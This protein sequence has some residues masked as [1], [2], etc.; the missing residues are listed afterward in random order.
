MKITFV[1]VFEQSQQ[2]TVS[3]SHI[4]EANDPHNRPSSSFTSF[5]L[6]FSM[7]ATNS[8][9]CLQFLEPYA[10]HMCHPICLKFNIP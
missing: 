7:I 8:N 6:V 5:F 10:A 2:I 4:F 3:Y 1:L 9:L